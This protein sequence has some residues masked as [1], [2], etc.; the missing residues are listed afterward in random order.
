M[1]HADAL[2]SADLC[3]PTLMALHDRF[4]EKLTAGEHRAVARALGELAHGLRQESGERPC[5]MSSRDQNAL[6]HADPPRQIDASLTM[7]R[8]RGSKLGG[9]GWSGPRRAGVVMS[10]SPRILVD[11]DDPLLRDVLRLS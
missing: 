1:Y 9:T 3:H 4:A 2:L 6:P 7:R 5:P 10:V 8:P 11:D